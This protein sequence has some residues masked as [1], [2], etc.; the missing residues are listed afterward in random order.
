MFVELVAEGLEHGHDRRDGRW[1]V[2]RGLI[3]LFATGVLE[4]CHCELRGW[5]LWLEKREGREDRLT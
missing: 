3:F 4:A 5:E 1:G 2:L